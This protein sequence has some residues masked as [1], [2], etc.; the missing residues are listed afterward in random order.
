MVWTEDNLKEFMLGMGAQQGIR[1][2]ELTS[3]RI[4]GRAA[5]VLRP[6]TYEQIGAAAAACREAGY[7]FLVLGR[8]T[9]VLASDKGYDGLVIRFDTPLHAP[10]YEGRRVTACCGMSLTQLARE[11]V[12]RGFSGMERLCGIPGSVGGACA[13]NAGAYG[14]EIKQIIKRIRL[15][16]DGVD[17][18]V[19]VQD[20]DLGY[21]TS[22]FSFPKAIA[23]EA[24]FE[25]AYDTG[26]AAQTMR[27]CT[28]RRREKQPIELPSAGSTFKRPAGH[29]AGALIEQCGLKGYTVGGAQVSEKH[30]GFLVNVGNAT[31]HD[32]SELIRYVQ[33]T[34][35]ERTGIRLECEI[36]R[37]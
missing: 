5:F 26:D 9:N 21:R 31:E 13:M 2:S 8:G 16:R 36:K 6:R 7:P 33:D 1:L 17:E 28:E 35:F 12:Q 23:L 27:E 11:T 20:A 29:F 14:A 22:A 24:E 18:W 3:F 25:L 34:V 19:D 15:L 32:V 37:I 10:V 30:A 4:G